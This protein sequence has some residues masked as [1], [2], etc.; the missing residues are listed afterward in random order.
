MYTDFFATEDIYAH[1][2]S[3][4]SVNKHSTE[5]KRD[6]GYTIERT[7]RLSEKKISYR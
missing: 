4:R 1:T 5:L 7:E 2:H 6:K 3:M